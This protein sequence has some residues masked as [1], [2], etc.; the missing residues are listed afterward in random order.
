MIASTYFLNRKLI[1]GERNI[2]IIS[3]LIEYY[4]I[5]NT[6]VIIIVRNDVGKDNFHIVDYK[7]ER[8]KFRTVVHIVRYNTFFDRI[9]E[10]N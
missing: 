7:W 2:I 5:H 4:N 1:L 8:S 3:K 9:Y 6:I 10:K